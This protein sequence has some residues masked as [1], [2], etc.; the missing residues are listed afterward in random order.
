M[1]GADGSDCAT[2]TGIYRPHHLLPMWEGNRSPLSKSVPTAENQKNNTFVRFVSINLHHITDS[3]SRFQAE[4]AFGSITGPA[5]LSRLSPRATREEEEEEKAIDQNPEGPLA[6]RKTE[7][8]VLNLKS[9]EGQV[10]SKRLPPLPAP[11]THCPGP[12]CSFAGLRM[13]SRLSL[14]A[15]SKSP[16]KNGIFPP[17]LS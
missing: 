17:Y 6:F 5:K 1:W 14:L 7:G 11:G 8:L 16:C 9:A 15:G 2:R 3:V 13:K 10:P 12:S 4:T